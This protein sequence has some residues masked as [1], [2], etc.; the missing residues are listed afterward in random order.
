MVQ[1]INVS[2]NDQANELV[3]NVCI[4]KINLQRGNANRKIQ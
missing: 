4:P 3:E 1:K 2:D